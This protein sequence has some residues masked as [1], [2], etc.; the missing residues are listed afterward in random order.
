LVDRV[1]STVSASFSNWNFE[2]S[3]D[4]NLLN[5]YQQAF[6]YLI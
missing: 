4:R 3:Y 2:L 5:L 1:G 6:D